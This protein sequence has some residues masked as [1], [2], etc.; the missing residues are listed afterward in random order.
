MDRCQLSFPGFILHFL[1]LFEG[2]VLYFCPCYPSCVKYRL[3][4]PVQDSLGL[5]EH[6]EGRYRCSQPG[7]VSARPPVRTIH[8]KVPNKS[9]LVLSIVLAISDIC[10]R[11]SSPKGRGIVR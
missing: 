7:S 6:T 2:I 10:T 4:R 11:L 5:M 9:G 3:S 8:V 1:P